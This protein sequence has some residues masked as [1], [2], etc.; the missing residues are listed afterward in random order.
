MLLA[1]IVLVLVPSADPTKLAAEYAKAVAEINDAH[2]A[3]PVARSEE[4]L[5]KKLPDGA[6]KALVELAQ[7]KESPELAAALATAGEAAL[8][9]DR[10]DDFERVRAR[11]AQVAPDDA[12]KLG[13]ALSRPRFVA[14]GTD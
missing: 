4:E 8:D 6:A 9:L 12:R 2:A 13:I 11:L 5:A 1:A 14:R 10:V 7:A 3:K